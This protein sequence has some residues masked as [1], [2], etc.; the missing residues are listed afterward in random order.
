MA[1]SPLRPLLWRPF[2]ENGAHPPAIEPQAE[3]AERDS[4]GRSRMN[5]QYVRRKSCLGCVLKLWTGSEHNFISIDRP[6]R[7]WQRIEIPADRIED[8]EQKFGAI[9]TADQFAAFVN[10]AGGWAR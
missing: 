1:T 8:V 3:D 5:R 6:G 9:E 4:H 2:V 10:E 7:N